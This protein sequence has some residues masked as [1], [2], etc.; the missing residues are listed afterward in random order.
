MQK[1][2]MQEIMIEITSL[3]NH[4]PPVKRIEILERLGKRARRDNSIET[5]KEVQRFITKGQQIK[6]SNEG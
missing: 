2:T 4:L 1:R 3:L 6:R 5:S